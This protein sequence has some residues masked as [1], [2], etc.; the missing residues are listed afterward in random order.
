[1]SID[2]GQLEFQLSYGDCDTV[3]I[4]YF[5]IYYRWME[6]CYSN[7]LFSHG[8]RSGQLLDQLGIVTVGVS[9]GADYLDT[10]TVFDVIQC[11]AVRDKIGASSYRVGFEFT[12]DDALITRGQ[13]TF[14]CRQPDFSKGAIP[15][16][17]REILMTLPEPR[18]SGRG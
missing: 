4:A 11:Q 5:G 13:I 12:R 6:R 2:Q 15:D 10:A 9:S 7:W 18:F 14:V 1:M 16:Q 17:L 8:L 3:G